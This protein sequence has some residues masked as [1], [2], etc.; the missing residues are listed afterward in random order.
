MSNGL[1]TRTE[2]AKEIN[3]HPRTVLRWMKKGM[4]Y[5]KVMNTTRFDLTEIKEWMKPEEVKK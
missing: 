1:L 3:V 4:P 5:M 2:L